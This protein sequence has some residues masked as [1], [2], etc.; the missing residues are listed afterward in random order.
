MTEQK[1]NGQG[2][3]MGNGELLVRAQRGD[4]SAFETLVEQH[5]D[6][7]Y[8]LGLQI[9]RSEVDAAEVA[10]QTFL[11]AYM[12]LNEFRSEAELGAGI[13]QMAANLA[14]TRLEQGNA[15]PV[16]EVALKLP[17]FDERGRFADYPETDWSRAANDEPLKADLRNVI[18]EATDRMPKHHRE[19]LL[20]R[21]VAG[22]SYE[23]IA[24]ITG[25][26]IPAIKRSL[27]LARLS[28]R[29]AIDRFYRGK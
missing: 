4:M 18:Q 7:V 29:E 10:Q 19:A 24:E 17:E 9:T 8:G 5:R 23:Q 15:A 6:S 12:G 27:H 25:D 14:L 16:G 2:T 3:E 1:Q 26:S 22:L 21:D 20:F 11:S 13:Q 28:L